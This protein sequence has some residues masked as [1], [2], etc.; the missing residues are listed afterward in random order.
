MSFCEWWT[1]REERAYGIMACNSTRE[2]FEMWKEFTDTL[3][4]LQRKLRHIDK[5]VAERVRVSTSERE[6]K[7]SR[8]VCLTCRRECIQRK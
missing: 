3:H 6:Q 5:E 2:L 7:P 1:K 4:I 8:N